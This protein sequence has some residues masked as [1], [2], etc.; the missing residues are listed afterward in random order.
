M[1]KNKI[2]YYCSECG[3]QSTKWQGQCPHCFAWNTMTEEVVIASKTNNRFSSL[4]QSTAIQKL[5]EVETSEVN[6]RKTGISEFDRVLGGGF[7]FGGVILLGGDPGI[8]KSTILI[9]A[10]SKITSQP[11]MPCNVI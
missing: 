2:A 5:S 4:T 8:G 9:Q 3:G 6:K 7:V 1:A 11:S 10:L